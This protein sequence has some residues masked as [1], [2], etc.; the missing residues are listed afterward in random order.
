MR[1]RRR[2]HVG[3]P[4]PPEP[5]GGGSPPSLTSTR[6]AGWG[7]R[8][9]GDFARIAAR[10]RP[11][12]WLRPG[13]LIASRFSG[14]DRISVALLGDP[15]EGDALLPSLRVDPAL[16]DRMRATRGADGRW[17]WTSQTPGRAVP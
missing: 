8:Q 2:A 6:D 15:G 4:A 16:E 1:L 13:P 10:S 7:C 17:G 5:P 3:T 12:S 11:L 14:R 9:I